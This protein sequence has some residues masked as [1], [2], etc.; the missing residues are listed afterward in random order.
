MRRMIEEMREGGRGLG[1]QRKGIKFKAIR[2][3]SENAAIEGRR[4]FHLLFMRLSKSNSAIFFLS[5]IM[6][7]SIS[8]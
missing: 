8:L 2:S 5:P 7:D 4:V 1:W 3:D 6:T